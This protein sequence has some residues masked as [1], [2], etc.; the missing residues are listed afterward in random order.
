MKCCKENEYQDRNRRSLTIIVDPSLYR[1]HFCREDLSGHGHEA[2]YPY[3]EGEL[4][5][6][7]ER[8]LIAGNVAMNVV[9][10]QVL[11]Q[12]G[13]CVDYQVIYNQCAG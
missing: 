3:I 12:C 10:L 13:V 5:Q 11:R 6:Y 7:V 1:F 9:S 2:W 4:F 8:F